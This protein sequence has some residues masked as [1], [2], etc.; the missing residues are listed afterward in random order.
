MNNYFKHNFVFRVA[1]ALLCF[2]VPTQA[3]AVDSGVL[4]A[5]TLSYDGTTLSRQNIELIEGSVEPRFFDSEDLFQLNV[6]AFDNTQLFTTE[7]VLNADRVFGMP[8]PGDESGHVSLE[9]V[10]TISTVT[11]PYFANARWIEIY[12]DGILRLIVDV[13]KFS[14]DKPD[15]EEIP[16]VGLGSPPPMELP[17][18]LAGV[19]GSF[20]ESTSSNSRF[21]FLFLLVAIGAGVI[22]VLQKKG[23]INK[24]PF[25]K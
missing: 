20:G 21:G 1:V 11:A 6:T 13:S 12:K 8:R 25:Q 24:F 7:F 16:L 5:L 2:F 18:D 9:N 17:P 22:F 23:L 19:P 3:Q 14:T 10:K 15:E 4:Y